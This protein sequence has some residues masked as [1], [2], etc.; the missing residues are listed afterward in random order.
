MDARSYARLEDFKQDLKALQAKLELALL[1]RSIRTLALDTGDSSLQIEFVEDLLTDAETEIIKPI[2][3]MKPLTANSELSLIIET[4][5]APDFVKGL[6]KIQ[7]RVVRISTRTEEL[8]DEEFI[9]E[10]LF[11]YVL[12]RTGINLKVTNE[13]IKSVSEPKEIDVNLNDVS[14]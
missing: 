6:E 2:I 4:K 9:L 3:N 12:P 8:L 5:N 7:T 13:I 1:T 10:Q 11:Y 14:C